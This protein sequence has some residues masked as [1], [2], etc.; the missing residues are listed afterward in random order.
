[1]KSHIV[2]PAQIREYKQL[3]DAYDKNRSGGIDTE[4]IAEAFAAVASEG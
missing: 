3:F 4:E 2:K 1:V